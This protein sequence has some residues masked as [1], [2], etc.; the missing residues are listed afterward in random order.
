ML[1]Y[2]NPY[3]PFGGVNNSGVGKSGGKS[4]FLE[5]TNKKSVLFQKSGFSIA[6]IIYPPYT[7]FKEKLAK[8]LG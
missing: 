6:K 3:L 2:A 5:F 8:F 1:Q 7:V 4:G